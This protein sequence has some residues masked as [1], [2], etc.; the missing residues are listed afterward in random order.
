MKHSLKVNR[1]VAFLHNRTSQ[2]TY[3]SYESYNGLDIGTT[4]KK[5]N[6]LNK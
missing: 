2:S 6:K 3:R 5:F 4:I 1:H